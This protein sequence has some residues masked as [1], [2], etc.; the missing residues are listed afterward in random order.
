MDGNKIGFIKFR[1]EM[2]LNIIVRPKV[3]TLRMI[4]ILIYNVCTLQD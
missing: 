3:D 4:K 1:R 2:E